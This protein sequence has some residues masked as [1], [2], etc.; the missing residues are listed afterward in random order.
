MDCVAG[1]PTCALKPLV[2]IYSLPFLLM[3]LSMNTL[4]KC[5]FVYVK[6]EVYDLV[7]INI[8]TLSFSVSLN[9]KHVA[10]QQF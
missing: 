5:V 3:L 2:T 7:T 8:L 6:A 9:S 1:R 10:V 4:D